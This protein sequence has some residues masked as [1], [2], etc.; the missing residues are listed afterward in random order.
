M[1]SDNTDGIGIAAAHL[2]AARL[3]AVARIVG[4]RGGPETVAEVLA[5]EAAALLGAAACVVTDFGR[6]GS[7][8]IL[9]ACNPSGIDQRSVERAA[10]RIAPEIAAAGGV[11]IATSAAVT[12]AGG[13]RP[14]LSCLGVPL[15][16]RAGEALGVAIVFADPSQSF[17]EEDGRW[18]MLAAAPLA[19]SLNA[20]ALEER[21]REL[22]GLVRRA[23]LGAGG[24]DEAAA[25][26][27]LRVLVVDDD[28]AVNDLLCEL[29]ALSGHRAEPAFDGLEAARLFDPSG[30]DLVIADVA[31]PR[32]NGWELASELRARAP[33]LPVVLVTGYGSGGWDESVL[34]RR[35]VWALLSKPVDQAQLAG[36][37]DGVV[38]GVS[39]R[40]A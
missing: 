9:A 15:G 10:T 30:H 26:H 40:A 11:L 36:I 2:R 22:E 39:A 8:S 20:R 18:L 19:A 21:V 23:E 3:G 12:L 5:A 37:L 31:M 14:G 27:A 33:R 28:R 13:A 16:S 7:P 35:G 32:M 38:A 29:V 17:D 34:R 6:N 24:S 1:T 25:G 4:A